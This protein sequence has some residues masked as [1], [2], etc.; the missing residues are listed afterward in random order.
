[1]NNPTFLPDL[2]LRY[3]SVASAIRI[4]LTIGFEACQPAPTERAEILE[5]LQMTSASVNCGAEGRQCA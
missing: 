3:L 5:V 1:M 4:D 2:D